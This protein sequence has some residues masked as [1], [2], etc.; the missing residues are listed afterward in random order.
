MILRRRL[1]RQDVNNY[2]QF[3]KGPTFWINNVW[4]VATLCAKL[5]PQA[6]F[7]PKN[8]FVQF[9][10]LLHTLFSVFR[11]S[12]S[13]IYIYIYIYMSLESLR[14]KLSND[15][16]FVAFYFLDLTSFELRKMVQNSK[17]LL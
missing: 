13:L 4:L 8:G 5:T 7:E 2:P 6:S 1:F 12:I 3:V 17:F 10:A 15:T 9:I 11:T 16:N 14:C